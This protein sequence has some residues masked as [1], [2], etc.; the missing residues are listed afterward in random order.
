[1]LT[2]LRTMTGYD[3]NRAMEWHAM[4]PPGGGGVAGGSGAVAAVYTIGV[5]PSATHKSG[6]GNLAHGFLA[7]ADPMVVLGNQVWGFELFLPE[8]IE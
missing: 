5:G 2:C 6:R 8:A 1:M 3:V 7:T 4:Q